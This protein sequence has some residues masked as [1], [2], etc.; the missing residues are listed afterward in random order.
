MSDFF[1]K[2][3]SVFVVEQTTNAKSVTTSA[4][5]TPAPTNSYRPA[6]INAVLPDGVVSDKFTDVLLKAMADANMEGFDY[7][8]YK[9]SLQNL[10]KMPMDEQLRYQSAYAM[11]QTMGVTSDKL[12][13][14]ALHY[15][16]IL[17]QEESKFQD[18]AN[19]QRQQQIGNKES[20]IQN[21][22][23]GIQQKAEQIKKL[24]EEINQ[25]QTLMEQIKQEI[26]EA[27]VKVTTAQNDF[28]ASLTSITDQINKDIVNMKNY[29]K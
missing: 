12:I 5:P 9:Q 21:L 13:N 7:F 15:I 10:S 28:S 4:A 24:T 26:Q 11:A 6:P 27:T 25:N 19:K 29:L 14:S 23:S 20:Q 2:M 17:K 8:E 1:K 3:K 22:N 18:A 16:N